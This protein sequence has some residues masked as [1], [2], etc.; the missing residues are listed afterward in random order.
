MDFL[1]Y[2]SRVLAKKRELSFYGG[3]EALLS[4]D[5]VIGRGRPE[6]AVGRAERV[7]EVCRKLIEETKKHL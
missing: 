4:P 7:Y 1:C 3:E 2:S 6:D 5:D